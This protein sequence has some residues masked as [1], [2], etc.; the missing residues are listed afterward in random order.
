MNLSNLGTFLQIVF[1][2]LLSSF[3]I[4]KLFEVIV[5]TLILMWITIY[6][7]RFDT[8]SLKFSLLNIMTYLFVLIYSRIIYL[9]NIFFFLFRNTANYNDWTWKAFFVTLILSTK[10]FQGFFT[11]KHVGPRLFIWIL[12][13]DFTSLCFIIVWNIY[14][15]LILSPVLCRF[16]WRSS[17]LTQFFSSWMGGIYQWGKLWHNFSQLNGRNFSMR[18]IMC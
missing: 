5:L 18:E 12:K 1:W 4:K 6:L 13:F 7:S 2:E 3:L 10:I 17:T 9:Y 14:V 16:I 15:T 11:L 8:F